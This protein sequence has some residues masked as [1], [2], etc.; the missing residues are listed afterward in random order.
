MSSK[1]LYVV[2]LGSIGLSKEFL[3]FNEEVLVLFA[4]G[5]FI[6]LFVGYGGGMVGEELDFRKEK[7]QE[8][9]DLY[10]NL[11][12]K[13]FAHL[14]SYHEK[15]KLLSFQVKEML[16]VSRSEILN[17]EIHYQ[18]SLENFLSLNFE[19]RLKRVS[20]NQNKTNGV[21]QK[22]IFVDLKLR[23]TECYSIENGK[24]SQKNRKQLLKNCVQQ[25]KTCC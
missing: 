21:L 14:V 20:V 7:I 22:E 1:Y 23:L 11:Q 25:L 19:E 9:F 15:Q 16:D 17:T 2:L 24:M 6:C 8:E 13:T 4:F 5:I 18:N 10:K 12:E 3:V